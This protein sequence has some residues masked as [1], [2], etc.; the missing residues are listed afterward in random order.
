MSMPGNVDVIRFPVRYM[1]VTRDFYLAQLPG[2]FAGVSPGVGPSAETA[3]AD[4]FRNY[5]ARNENELQDASG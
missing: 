1:G 3:V 2:D 4:L 5:L